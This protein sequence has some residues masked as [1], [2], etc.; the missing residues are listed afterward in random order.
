MCLA[1]PGLI[2]SI[3]GKTAKVDFGGG[4]QR[5]IDVSLVDV[6]VGQYV[7]VHTGFAIEVLERE[8]ALE[9][10]RVWKEILSHQES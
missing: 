7:L 4:T 6:T 2:T 5:D 3:E 1:I 8:D 9:T 10:I